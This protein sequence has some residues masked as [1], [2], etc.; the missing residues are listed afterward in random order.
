[1][2]ANL[3]AK[4][5][6]RYD[7]TGT[8]TS[9]SQA[10]MNGAGFP[11]FP[12]TPIEYFADSFSSGMQIL[13]RL[14]YNNILPNV[15]MQPTVAFTQDLRGNTPLPLGNFIHGRKS[16]NLSVEF[17]YRNAWALEFRYVNFTGAGKYNLF[18]DRDYFA[19][20]VKYSF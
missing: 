20:T 5:E 14:D 3:P 6:L 9:A 19:T 18:S 12:A 4:E 13:G 1:M 11:T 16:L 17:I 15:N 2:W 8:F 10:F 7:G